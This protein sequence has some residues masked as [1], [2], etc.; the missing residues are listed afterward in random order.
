MKLRAKAPWKQAQSSNSGNF[1]WSQPLIFRGTLAVSFRVAFLIGQ[2]KTGP[3]QHAVHECLIDGVVATS[4][5]CTR[6]GKPES[7]VRGRLF[8]LQKHHKIVAREWAKVANICDIYDSY[9]YFDMKHIAYQLAVTNCN[10]MLFPHVASSIL[11]SFAV[12]S[13]CSSNIGVS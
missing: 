7:W 10:G 5:Y 4:I 3:A 11:L 6:C 1:I 13:C 12:E 9:K 2:A 8:F